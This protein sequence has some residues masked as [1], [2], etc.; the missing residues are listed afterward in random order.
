L[1]SVFQNVDKPFQHRSNELHTAVNAD[2][3][4]IDVVCRAAKAG[5][6]A[7]NDHMAVMRMPAPASFIRVKENLAAMRIRDPLKA[8]KDA[9]PAQIVSQLMRDCALRQS[10]EQSASS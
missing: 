8:C 10:G 2:G 3:F 4:E 7:T 9:L 6:V 5:L 1:L